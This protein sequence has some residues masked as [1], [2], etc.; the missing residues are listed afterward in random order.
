M[1]TG[2]WPVVIIVTVFMGFLMGYSL[3]PM[4]EVGL[5]GGVPDQ[6]L[7]VKSEIGEDM[8]QYYKDLAGETE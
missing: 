6:E 2:L 8:E 7:G 1:R 3:P 4:L 5:I